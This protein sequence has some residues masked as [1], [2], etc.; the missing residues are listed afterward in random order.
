M[1]A[2]PSE[3]PG[4]NNVDVLIVIVACLAP[5]RE[6]RL[7]NTA[8]KPGALRAIFRIVGAHR[9]SGG[10]KEANNA[11]G[12]NRF[13]VASTIALRVPQIRPGRLPHPAPSDRR[14]LPAASRLVEGAD[15][16]FGF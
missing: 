16:R 2:C 1:G 15:R 5:S 4:S 12:G 8:V 3:V 7:K 11:K 6:A 14:P 10:G 13:S 9:R